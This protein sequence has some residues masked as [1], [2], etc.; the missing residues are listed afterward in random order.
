M[1]ATGYLHVGLVLV[2]TGFFC[3]FRG[4]EQKEYDKLPILRCYIDN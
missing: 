3:Y 2:L 4:L 1:L